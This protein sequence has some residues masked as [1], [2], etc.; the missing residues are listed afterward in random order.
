MIVSG[1]GSIGAGA[2]PGIGLGIGAVWQAAVVAFIDQRQIQ[3]REDRA[4]QM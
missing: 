1:A 2:E 3:D 4:W